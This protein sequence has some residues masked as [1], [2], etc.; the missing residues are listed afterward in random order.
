MPAVQ[1]SIAELGTPAPP[2]SLTDV[3]SGDIVD[4]TAFDGQPWLVVFL[5]AHCP[6]VKHI[7]RRLAELGSRYADAGLAVVAIASNDPVAN[8]EDSPEGLAA[9]ARRAG[10]TFPYVFDADQSIARAFG[11]VCTPDF[12]LYDRSHEL[13]YRGRFDASRPGNDIEVT[14][15]DL[16]GAIDRVLAGQPVPVDQMVGIGCSIKWRDPAV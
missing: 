9:Q 6:Y 1:P 2:F 12:F 4:S 5:C 3:R 10:F 15:D 16:A 11:A 13:A 8:I 7:E 14:G